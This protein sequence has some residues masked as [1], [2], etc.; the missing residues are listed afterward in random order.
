VWNDETREELFGALKRQVDEMQ[1]EALEPDRK[2]FCSALLD[3][4]YRVN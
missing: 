1:K 3:F 4:D 2:R